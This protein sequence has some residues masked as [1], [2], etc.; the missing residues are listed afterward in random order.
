M[1][2]CGAPSDD[3]Y[4]RDVRQVLPQL[5]NK[6]N[7]FVYIERFADPA[8]AALLAKR[9]LAGVGFYSEQRRASNRRV[10]IRVE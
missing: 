4:V 8:K 2:F 1:W 6:R 7:Q 3:Q 9:N 5:L 10:V